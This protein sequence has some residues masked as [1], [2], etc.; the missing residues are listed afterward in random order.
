MGS[1]LRLLA[2]GKATD[3][4]RQRP[5][6]F[7]RPLYGLRRW[8]SLEGGTKFMVHQGIEELY[9]LAA[10]PGE[11]TNLADTVD[12]T[13]A[14]VA[15]GD[16]LDR[17]VGVVWRLVLDKSS[18]GD[19][20]N[21]TLNEAVAAA[22]VGDDPTMKG[23]ASVS[24]ADAQTVIRW[25]K[26][27]GMVE[28]FLVPPDPLPDA[29]DV[30]ISI[31]KRTETRTVMLVGRERPTAGRPDTLFIERMAGRRIRM[32]TTVAPLP[33]DLD[34]AIQGFDSEVAGDLESLGYIDTDD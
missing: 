26:Q 5:Q 4:F 1:D 25:P 29:I 20:V 7:G 27:R 8:G 9:N 13:D 10:D 12:T 19:A 21:V 28:V 2:S 15:L 30:D 16:A 22:W 24:I 33:S 23:K 18:S 17:P 3:M 14:K 34:G 6:A 31:G 11:Q 32:T